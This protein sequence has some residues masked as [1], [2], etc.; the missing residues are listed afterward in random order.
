MSQAALCSESLR[1]DKWLVN[2][3]FFKRRAL[4]AELAENKRIRVNSQVVTKAHYK[5]RP[6]DV[7]TFPQAET[8]RVVRVLALPGRRGS[9]ALAHG[10]Y[11]D[12]S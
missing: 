10:C 11:E 4:A 7:L 1:L 8:I 3:R 9:S 2:A 6:G 12:L 5:L